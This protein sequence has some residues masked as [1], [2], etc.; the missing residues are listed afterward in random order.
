MGKMQLRQEARALQGKIIQFGRRSLQVAGDSA[1]AEF[2]SGSEGLVH[3]AIDK[4]TGEKFRIKCFWE[5]DDV[6]R[7]RSEHLV[8]LHL[9]DL[10][11]SKADALAGAPFGMLPALGPCTPFALV[12]RNVRGESWRKLRTRAEAD[13]EYPPSWWPSDAIRATWAYGLA[14]AVMKMEAQEFVHADLSPGNVVV[15]DGLHGTAGPA[16][17]PQP[18]NASDEAGD[19]ALVDF[20]RYV[21]G[22]AEI[23]ELGQGT[24]GYAA[25]EVWEKRLPQIGTDRTSMA[26]LIQEFLVVGSLELRKEQALDWSFDQDSRAFQLESDN[27]RACAHPGLASKYPRLAKLVED[28][29]AATGPDTR[30]APQSWRGPLRDI[31]DP[32]ARTGPQGL[33]ELTVEEVTEAPQPY[34]LVFKVAMKMLD[35]SETRFR[36][37]ASLKRDPDGTIYLSVHDKNNLNV[38]LPGSRVPQNY[39]AGARVE[40]QTGLVL[41]GSDGAIS[42]R[43]AGPR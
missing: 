41:I 13:S 28:T 39:P 15:N 9:P 29:V 35:L 5:P 30:P 1:R 11:K 8:S 4:S 27:I 2:E 37:A 3:L 42:A 40:V 33:R 38:Q 43:L 12:A 31:V 7:R 32:P 19:M 25:P 17:A 22:H 34:R 36:L 6:R 26:I 14:T 18:G 10:N 16:N 23:S 24:A 21:H 20:D